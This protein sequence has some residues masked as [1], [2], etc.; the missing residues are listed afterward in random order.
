MEDGKK[1]EMGHF[2]ILFQTF[3]GWLFQTK[4]QCNL[5][6]EMSVIVLCVP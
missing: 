5:K 6:Q 2:K 4:N 3:V 1:C